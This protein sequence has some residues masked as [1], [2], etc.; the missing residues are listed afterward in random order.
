MCLLATAVILSFVAHTTISRSEGSLAAAQYDAL[1]NQ[2]DSI[3]DRALVAALGIKMRKR[4]G[5]IS[6]S[7]I[8]S[9]SLPNA[10]AWPFVTLPGFEEIAT[11]LVKTSSGK[12]L[13]YAPLVAP[14]EL[15]SF[16]GFA[17][18][19]FENKHD[20]PFPNGTGM[21][22]FG[23]GIWGLDPNLNASDNRYRVTYA[24]ASYDSPNKVFFPIL[25]HSGGAHRDLMLDLH[26][27]EVR[28]ATID[29]IIECA[30]LRAKTGELLECGA[31][32]PVLY[33]ATQTGADG[34]GAL[35]FQPVFPVNNLTKVSDLK[36]ASRCSFFLSSHI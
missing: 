8:I 29:R 27:E 31:I 17:Y 15:P 11:N 6:L 34:L 28:G 24:N 12:A 1:A 5:T 36:F 26:F 18:D 3:A 23:K 33:L 32:T 20:P 25:Q 9:Y 14:G 2:Y 21:S 35:M 4:L 16:E 19:F 13:S 30:Q 7:T 22:S 10:E